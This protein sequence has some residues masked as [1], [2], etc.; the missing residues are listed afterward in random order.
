MM[1]GAGG[2]ERHVTFPKLQLLSV[3]V[4]HSAP[5]E[6]DVELVVGIYARW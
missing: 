2:Y 4:E 5:F 3:D 1:V 6:D